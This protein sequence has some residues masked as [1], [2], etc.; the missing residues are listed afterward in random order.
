MV[1]YVCSKGPE[2]I[3]KK[4]NIFYGNPAQGGLDLLHFIV[5]FEKLVSFAY[6]VN[7]RF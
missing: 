7:L 6:A 5:K 3:I 2:K 1:S 4:N